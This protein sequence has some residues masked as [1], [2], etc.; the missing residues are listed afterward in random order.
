MAQKRNRERLQEQAMYDM[1][2]SMNKRI[3]DDA[4]AFGVDLCVMNGL[5]NYGETVERCKKYCLESF[6]S[7]CEQCIADWLNEFPF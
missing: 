6:R 5:L 7:G 3:T 4:G 2:L 1:L